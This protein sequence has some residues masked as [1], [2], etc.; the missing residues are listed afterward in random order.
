MNTMILSSPS[1]LFHHQCHDL[2][3]VLYSARSN[4]IFHLDL[5]NDTC[6]TTI[7]RHLLLRIACLGHWVTC[8]HQNNLNGWLCGKTFICY[9]FQPRY[10]KNY[11][12]CNVYLR[13]RCTHTSFRNFISENILS[14]G[15]S[16]N[17]S[18]YAIT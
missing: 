11:V 16:L 14:F 7:H 10:N 15:S 8:Q 17:F 13:E 5:K 2:S 4:N 3:F 12:R 18:F 9:Y 6:C 1:T